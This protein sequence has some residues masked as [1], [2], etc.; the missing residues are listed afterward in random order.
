L[1]LSLKNTYSILNGN[2]I[3]KE[4]ENDVYRSL[5]MPSPY[6]SFVNID[7]IHQCYRDEKFFHSFIPDTYAGAMISS[8]CGN[9]VF[10]NKPFS[11]SGSSHHSNALGFFNKKINQESNK[12]FL[13]ENDLNI[14]PKIEIGPSSALLLAEPLLQAA[15][16]LQSFKV[17]IYKALDFA[18][19]EAKYCGDEEVYNL[20]TEKV[21]LA[22]IKN[23]FEKR[24]NSVI[25]KNKFVIKE[26]TNKVK[27]SILN[28]EL[29]VL[30]QNLNE[31]GFKLENIYDAAKFTKALLASDSTKI[32]VEL[33]EIRSNKLLRKLSELL[34]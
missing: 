29:V 4:T 32:E 26:P 18:L 10:S 34:H 14:H 20:I 7:L 16:R 33:R 27:I 28:N 22:A 30:T 25:L 19:W 9:Y 24:I 31:Q 1:R 21:K 23:G 17:N 13:K 5:K 15:D 3:L 11:I 6:W 2:T 8:V 12:A